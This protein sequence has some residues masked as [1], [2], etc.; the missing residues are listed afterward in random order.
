MLVKGRYNDDC[1][2]W[3]RLPSYVLLYFPC[4]WHR[5]LSMLLYEPTSQNDDVL[6]NLSSGLRSE[7]RPHV[8]IPSAEIHV[9]KIYTSFLPALEIIFY[10]HNTLL[11]P[12]AHCTL[13][14]NW[15]DAMNNTSP[16]ICTIPTFTDAEMLRF[17]WNF[18]HWLHCK[19]SKWQLPVQPETN[20]STKFPFRC[21]WWILFASFSSLV[22]FADCPSGNKEYG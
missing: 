21:S 20:I 1:I 17:W 4:R 12:V 2:Q 19:L 15:V 14:K 18:H 22:F 11:H 3:T 10:H 6:S 9:N 5:Y 8:R 13:L 16:K 7:L